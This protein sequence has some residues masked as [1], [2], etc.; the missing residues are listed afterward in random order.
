MPAMPTQRLTGHHSLDP[1]GDA[2]DLRASIAAWRLLLTVQ[3]R[4]L[5]AVER[6]LSPPRSPAE[7]GAMRLRALK[8]GGSRGIAHDGTFNP[9]VRNRRSCTSVTGP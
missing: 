1:L 5:D 8:A 2:R 3:S 6:R 9:K 4:R 7:P